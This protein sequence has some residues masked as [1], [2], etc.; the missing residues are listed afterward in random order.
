MSALALSVTSGG[1]AVEGRA[2]NSFS[3]GTAIPALAE[4]HQAP[5]EALISRYQ[6]FYLDVD[7]GVLKYPEDESYE[8]LMSHYQDFYLDVDPGVLKYR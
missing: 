1:Q 2:A 4:V 8:A 5:Y 7:P 6:N 3:E